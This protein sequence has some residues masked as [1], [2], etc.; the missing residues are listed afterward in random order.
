MVQTAYEMYEIPG[1]LRRVWGLRSSETLRR[2]V[3]C[4]TVT[5]V[6]GQILVK[7]IQ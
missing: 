6:S 7:F 4:Q 3:G 1:Y 2:G 5:V